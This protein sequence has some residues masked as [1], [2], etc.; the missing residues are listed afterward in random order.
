M[1][2]KLAW[3]I[4][5]RR[6]ERYRKASKHHQA[7]HIRAAIATRE[8]K[9]CYLCCILENTDWIAWATRFDLTADME[10]DAKLYGDIIENESRF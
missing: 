8:Q 7:D 5:A 1:L 4:L 6:M 2:E 10:K 3:R 9:Q